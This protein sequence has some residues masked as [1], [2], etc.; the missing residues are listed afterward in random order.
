MLKE[1]YGGKFSLSPAFSCAPALSSYSTPA[2]LL[3][4]TYF[5]GRWPLT[6]NYFWSP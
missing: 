4:D 1:S 2:G 5:K 6:L 3:Y